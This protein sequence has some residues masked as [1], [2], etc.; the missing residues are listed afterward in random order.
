M[1]TNLVIQYILEHYGWFVTALLVIFL[2]WVADRALGVSPEAFVR[3]LAREFQD[4]AS[5]QWTTGAVDAVALLVAFI[6]G[7][8]LIAADESGELR[9]WLSG[10]IEPEKAHEYVTSVSPNALF[11]GIV[12]L[13]ALSVF[14]TSRH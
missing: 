1:S 6:F 3:A 13:A 12:S 4:L 5:R 9:S 2:M 8:I 10:L 7:V 11:I 14:F